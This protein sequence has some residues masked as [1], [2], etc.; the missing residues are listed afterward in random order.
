ML[1]PFK[2]TARRG[3]PGTISSTTWAYAGP[4]AS[5]EA[6]ACHALP[7]VQ[8]VK[9]QQ[10]P[11]QGTYQVQYHAHITAG[12]SKL[13]YGRPLIPE[14][15]KK[16]KPG[17]NHPT[18]IFQ[19]F[20]VY[21]SCAAMPC[22]TCILVQLSVTATHS[23][24]CPCSLH[25]MGASATWLP[26]GVRSFFSRDLVG[27]GEPLL[28]HDLE[29]QWPI[30][31]GAATFHESCYFRLLWLSRV[32]LGLPRRDHSTRGAS[33]PGGS[34]RGGF[35]NSAADRLCVGFC[36]FFRF[37]HFW[38]PWVTLQGCEGDIST[39]RASGLAASWSL[40]PLPAARGLQGPWQ[41]GLLFRNLI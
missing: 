34:S 17:M 14:Q 20:E 28:V 30:I 11:G 9:Q 3:S 4:T 10:T 37:P 15:K 29:S 6:C 16:G 39:S 13:E 27:Y 33:V 21:R 19:L 36:F 24:A 25:R 1:Y 32:I 31:M 8:L 41:S 2:D 38:V 23:E 26:G 35:K 18:S 7:P 12:A 5:C 22:L 40:G